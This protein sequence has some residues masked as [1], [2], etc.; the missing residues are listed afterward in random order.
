L[1]PTLVKLEI[2]DQ[3]ELVI[4]GKLA[5][6]NP[7][8]VAASKNTLPAFWEQC[9]ADGTFTALEALADF[10]HDPAYVGYADDLNFV[11]P[12]GD[13]DYICGMMMKSGTPVPNGF[14]ARTVLP[15]KVAV[16]WVKG[17]DAVDICTNANANA[18][19]LTMKAMA[20]RGLKPN[21][22]FR[23]R[24]WCMEVYNKERFT[25]PDAEGNIIVDFYVPVAETPEP[26]TPTN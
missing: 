6:P 20:E 2:I 19:V 23:R 9:F 16:A 3:P 7:N 17:K 14:V 13:F 10:I 21:E 11:P 18:H 25:T 4:V 8:D 26:S 1:E 5:R 12:D 22:E 15:V 24:C